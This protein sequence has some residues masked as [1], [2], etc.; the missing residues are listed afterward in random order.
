M[1]TNNRTVIFIG[2]LIFA[3]L[4]IGTNLANYYFFA[5]QA[6]P[7]AAEDPANVIRLEPRQVDPPDR[8]QAELFW[9]TIETVRDNYFY[10]VETEELVEGA[11]RGMIENIGDPNVRFYDPEDLEEFLS[12]TRGTYGGIGVRVIEAND[13]IVVFETFAGSPAE[14][15]GLS[16]GDRI[17]EAD[18]YELTGEGLNRAVELLRGPGD[19]TV[20][21]LISRPG[22]DEPIELTVGRAE[23]QVS[24]V[25]SEMIEDGLGYI[26]ITNFDGNT[27]DEFE[28]QFRE[29][30]QSGLSRGLILDLRNNPGG[31]VDAVVRIGQK[32]VPEGEIVRLVGREG[33]VK[34]VHNSSAVKRPY[35]IVVLINE[36]SASASELL[37][38]AL[39]DREAAVL[40]GQTTYGKASVQQLEHLPEG[41]AVLLTVAKYFTPSGHD[42][43]KHGIE[44]DFKV[45]MPEILRYYRYFHPGSLEEGDYGAEVEMLQLMLEQLGFRLD[46][47]G[48]FDGQTSRAL[49]NFQDRA[50]LELTGEFDDKTWVELREALDIA[51]RENDEQLNYAIEAIRKPG[52]MNV[53]GGLE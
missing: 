17:L 14:R 42:I 1:A 35:P 52:L 5:G 41:N 33:E 16:P 19:T 11:V 53:T 24:S 46:V 13:K 32:L 37:A 27:Y 3:V 15:S 44:P 20:D 28:S 48:Y 49:R 34:T 26:K 25:F 6:G 4:L 30:E 38:G 12:E 10:P 2:L 29:I 31:L 23:I 45:D 43:D 39:Q 7:A 9:K 36:E 8:D 50:G 18:G 51:A 22:A 21:I 47:T 40:I